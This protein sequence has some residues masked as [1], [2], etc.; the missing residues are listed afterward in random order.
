MRL[1]DA[2]LESVYQIVSIDLPE[3]SQRHLSNL[4]LKPG[5][6]LKYISKTA[7]GGI[8]LVKSTR[9]AFDRSI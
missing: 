5:V 3:E 4:G 2:P 8:V 6:N 9:L 1:L 7:T